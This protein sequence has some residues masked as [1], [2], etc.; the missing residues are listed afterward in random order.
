M[1]EQIDKSINAVRQAGLIDNGD[2]VV[3]T[4]GMPIG[5]TGSTNMLKVRTVEDLCF[6]GQGAG[7]HHRRGYSSCVLNK[8]MTGRN[9]RKRPSW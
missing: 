6:I 4:A 1:D 8:K 7:G 9:Y 5:T 2:L 3:L